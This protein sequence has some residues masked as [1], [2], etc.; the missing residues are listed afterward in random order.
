MT[1]GVGGSDAQTELAKLNNMTGDVEP[2]SS[3]E[4]QLRIAKAQQLMKDNNIEATYLDAG[5]NLYYF[6]G[7]KWYASERMVGAIIPQQGD[8]QYITPFFEVNTLRQYMTI[9][10]KVNGWQEHENP[11]QLFIETLKNGD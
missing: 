7:T 4:F 2:I 11:Y 9:K 1:I 8:I 6:T 5:T 10:G 3:N